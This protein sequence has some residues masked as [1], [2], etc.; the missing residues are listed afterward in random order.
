MMKRPNGFVA[1]LG[2][3]AIL[4][5]LINLTLL[6]FP[7]QSFFMAFLFPVAYFLLIIGIACCST[8]DED[9][10]KKKIW[11]TGSL[12]VNVFLWIVSFFI[13]YSNLL[14]YR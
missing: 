5:L 10:D 2:Y 14:N 3:L 8:L 13:F 12:V 11:I 4:A 9:L 7:L 6:A 1:I